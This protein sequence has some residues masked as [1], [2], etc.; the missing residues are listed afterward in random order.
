MRYTLSRIL[1]VVAGAY[2]IAAC[3]GS[4]GDWLKEEVNRVTAKS[5]PLDASTVAAGLREAL[6]QGTARAVRDLGRENG[7][8]SK[9]LVRIPMPEKLQKVDTALRRLGQDKLADDFVHSLNRAAEHAT[10]EAERIFVDAVRRMTIRDALDILHGPQNAATSYFRRQTEAPLAQAFHPIVARS[11]AA[12]GVTSSY[13]RLVSRAEPLGLIDTHELDIDDY[14]T[15]K[16]LDGL[17]LMIAEEE[18]RIREDPAART[19]ELLRKVFR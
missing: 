6:D 14:V 11:T 17:F 13:K 16:T 15:R 5:T 3:A 10:P 1:L 7:F 18:R 12:V 2:A 8:W 4:S 19:T 9:P